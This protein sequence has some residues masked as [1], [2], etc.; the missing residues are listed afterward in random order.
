M[1]GMN[2]NREWFFVLGVIIIFLTLDL[3]TKEWA[4]KN[5]NISKHLFRGKIQL[6]YVRNYGIAF[7]RLSGK[8]NLILIINLFLFTYLGYLL[9][10]DINNYLAYSLILAGGLGNFIGRIQKGYV[11]DFIYFNIQGWPVFNIAD[12]EVLLGISIVMVREIIG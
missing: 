10:T 9:Y 3:R 5:L 11:I 4:E 7:N 12:F 6:I 8:K 2:L 1:I